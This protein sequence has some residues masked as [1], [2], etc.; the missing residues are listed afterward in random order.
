MNWTSNQSSVISN[1]DRLC[2]KEPSS[3][4]S[5]S[6]IARRAAEDHHSSLERKH[7]FT[8]IELL[9][10]IAIIAI[11]AGMLL[12]ALN[13]ARETAK[14]TQCMNNLKSIN[15]MIHFYVDDNNEHY[16]TFDIYRTDGGGSIKWYNPAGGNNPL[17][18]YFKGAD[19]S[20]SRYFFSVYKNGNNHR[21]ICPNRKFGQY[22]NDITATYGISYGY[23][24]YFNNVL[25]DRGYRA[26]QIIM[27]S[28]TA[29]MA[30]S[31]LPNWAT[32]ENA[33]TFK[34]ST[35]TA[36]GNRV[37]TAFCDGRAEAVDYMK[38]PNGSYAR[39]PNGKIPSQ[40]IFFIPG[41]NLNSGYPLRYFD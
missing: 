5:S 28:R 18:S 13:K 38:I 32:G 10:V 41:Y 11:L 9:V 29:F 34:E 27:P 36:H 19:K 33:T 23:S 25:A 20:T 31:F 15:S 2:R 17:Y 37:I 14:A 3:F 40:H 24:I 39:I 21:L 30:E 6:S 35:I 16:F 4:I 22:P 1:Q 26:N 7:I 12:P 8:L